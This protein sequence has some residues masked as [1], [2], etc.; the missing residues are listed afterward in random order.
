[1][2][3]NISTKGDFVTATWNL[4]TFWSTMKVTWESSISAFQSHLPTYK[5]LMLTQT[6]DG[7]IFTYRLKN[8]KNFQFKMVRS[9]MCFHLAWYCLWCTLSSIHSLV[10]MFSTTSFIDCYSWEK[11]NN[12]GDAKKKDWRSSMYCHYSWRTSFHR[13]STRILNIDP[14]SK[15]YVTIL[16]SKTSRLT[17]KKSIK[18]S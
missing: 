2:A 5:I 15:K 10:T 18:L 3:L 13:W 7:T 12:F 8:V 1:M 4:K 16:G 6:W 9:L 11:L 17:Q 14:L